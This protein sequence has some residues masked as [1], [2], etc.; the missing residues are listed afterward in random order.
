[1]VT[2]PAAGRPARRQATPTPPPPKFAPVQRP[3]APPASGPAA[4][5]ARSPSQTGARSNPGA[6]R[7][8]FRTRAAALAC[9]PGRESA[10]REPA[11]SAN[12]DCGEASRSGADGCF[13]SSIPAGRCNG[14]SALLRSD[15]AIRRSARRQERGD[16][17]CGG[18]GP[19]QAVR[20]NKADDTQ[21][22]GAPPVVASRRDRRCNRLRRRRSRPNSTAQ[23]SRRDRM[24]R[25]SA[26]SRPAPKSPSRNA[27]FGSPRLLFS[28]L[29]LRWREPQF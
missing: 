24:R 21:A 2:P 7:T 10:S 8:R 17:R 23:L 13:A 6:N 9:T 18:A 26:P 16:P 12:T 19:R 20:P 25:F 5:T 14:K 28:A 3:A 4:P 27:C 11:A 1:M 15:S 29:S 22:S